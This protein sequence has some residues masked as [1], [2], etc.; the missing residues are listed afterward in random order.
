M[1]RV[2]TKEDFEKW[3]AEHGGDPWGYEKA[4]VKKRLFASI[5]FVR[6]YAP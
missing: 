6:L 4:Y 1:K 5:D 2:R 3:Y